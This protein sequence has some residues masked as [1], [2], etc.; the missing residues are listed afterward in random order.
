[1]LSTFGFWEIIVVAALGFV[2]WQLYN[3]QRKFDTKLI[4]LIAVAVYMLYAGVF[5]STTDFTA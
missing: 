5:N 3:E 4:I 2:A 1:M